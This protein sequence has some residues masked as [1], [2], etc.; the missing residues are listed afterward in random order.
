METKKQHKLTHLSN[1]HFKPILFTILITI[2]SCKKIT[3]EEEDT[4]TNKLKLEITTLTKEKNTIEEEKNTKQDLLHR[5]TQAKNDLEQKVSEANT[6]L[7]TAEQKK[8]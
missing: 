4:D 2:L 3:H 5:T 8:I 1:Y 6:A 7:T